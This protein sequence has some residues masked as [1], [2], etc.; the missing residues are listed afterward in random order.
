[1][2]QEKS[3]L[4]QWTFFCLYFLCPRQI[5]TERLPKVQLACRWTFWILAYA[6]AIFAVG[7]RIPRAWPMNGWNTRR[8][9]VSDTRLVDRPE[10][11]APPG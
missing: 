6:C 4:K 7:Y 10:A 1:M 8:D 11:L 5:F 2:N 3:P 9:R